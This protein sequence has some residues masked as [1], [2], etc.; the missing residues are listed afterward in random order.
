MTTKKVSLT[1]PV[2]FVVPAMYS[3]GKPAEVAVAL[4]LGA[5]ATAYIQKRGTET[6]R[7]ETHAE[8]VVQA[9][10]EF[11]V[12]LKE[13]ELVAGKEMAKLRQDK[14]KAEE[15]ARAA[16]LRIEAMESSASVLRLQIQKEVRESMNELLAAKDDHIQRL[17]QNLEKSVDTVGK[18][19]ESL[20]QSITKTFASSKEKGNFGEFMIEAQL[21]R[22][23]D[24]DVHIVSK[25]AETADIRMTRAAGAY[26][27]EV[28][29]Y[30]R[31][32][33]TEEVNKFRRDLRL[34][35]DVRGGILVSLRY[36]I[37]GK[38]RGGD[39]D[40]EFLEDGRFILF[41]STFMAHEDTVF[42]LQT[43]RPF[44][45]TIE[46][47][48]KPVKEE[49][50]AIRAL[51]MKAALMTNLLRSHAVSVT[52]HKNALVGHKRRTDSMFA[53]FSSYIL[54]AEAQLQA[55]LRVAMGGDGEVADVLSETETHLS[56]I[57]FAKER[58]SDCGEER[59]REFVKWLLAVAE[60]RE[61]TQLEL[62]DL[63]E[64]AR[65]GG[66]SEKWVRG[67]REDL[68]QETAW[69][70]GSRFLMGMRWIPEKID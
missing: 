9:A 42:Y 10:K 4:R 7:Q 13:A 46:A 17:Q 23:F 33:S 22:A 45:E 51:E 37:V 48:A 69:P 19:V 16:Q 56:P 59:S 52:K 58:L 24:C 11:E 70:K 47:M 53:E 65:K 68:F 60:V 63:L 43:L 25:G 31:M 29:N 38:A 57:V 55:I 64:R 41:I 62:K 26:L 8:A 34:H 49:V 15:A 27:W 67:I 2:D 18:R 14:L 20:Q 44:F 36:G 6:L 3:E 61:G 32:V 40:V 21:K 12:Q 39:I 35:P 66:Y 28:K 5:E 54:E 50:E 1:I 30:T